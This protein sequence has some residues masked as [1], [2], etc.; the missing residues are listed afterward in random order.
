MDESTAKLLQEC[1]LGCHMAIGSM[2]QI[3]SLIHI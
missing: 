1:H 3:L 2:E